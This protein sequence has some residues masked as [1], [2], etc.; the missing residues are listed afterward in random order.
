V[1]TSIAS[2]SQ[3]RAG[4]LPLVGGR[5]CLDFVNTSSGRGTPTHQDHLRAYND[6][7]AWAHHADALDKA[8]TLALAEL[9]ARKPAAARRVLTRATRLRETLFAIVTALG[10]KTA[11]A[12]ADL[13]AL[14]AYL[15]AANR[16]ARLERSKRGFAWT[17]ASAPPQLELPLWLIARSAADVLTAGPLERLKSCN[18]DSCG[19]VFL[20]QT[21]NGR[22][23]WCEM[24]ICGSRAKMRRF[25]AR[26][27][28]AHRASRAA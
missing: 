4:R 5:L 7:L 19:W 27:A 15:A 22:R 23:R 14:N 1:A 16:S 9:A 25:R 10:R 17:W 18:G 13:T 21:R 20:D 8:T 28:A 24:E 26:H 3:G 12:A 2:L 11:P 6:L